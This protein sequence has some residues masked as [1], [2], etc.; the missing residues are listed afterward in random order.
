MLGRYEQHVWRCG[1]RTWWLVVMYTAG[2]CRGR[3]ERR[4]TRVRIT[5]RSRSPELYDSPGPYFTTFILHRVA[6][7]LGAGG[8]FLAARLF[9]AS[10]SNLI[11]PRMRRKRDFQNFCCKLLSRTKC[12]WSKFLA[13]K[14]IASE[15][16]SNI[17][18]NMFHSQILTAVYLDLLLKLS[19]THK[20]IGRTHKSIHEGKSCS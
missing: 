10:V 19:Q 20:S 14:K 7:N 2:Q 4:R 8:A 1:R 16:M 9:L 15:A 17:R 3:E 11:S 13:S 6:A 5:P 18:I 12:S